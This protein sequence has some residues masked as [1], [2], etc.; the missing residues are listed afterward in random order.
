MDKT[1]VS[2]R[3]YGYLGLLPFLLLSSFTFVDVNHAT[4]WRDAYISYSAVILAFMAGVYWPLGLRHD[5]P[6][7]GHRLMAIAI[8]GALVAWIAVVLPPLLSALSFSSAFLLMFMIDRFVLA[9]YWPSAYLQMRAHLTGV[10]V[11]TQVATL[12]AVH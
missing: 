3:W 10:V 6:A 11:L 4:L 7:H 9:D 8:A 2:M 1:W 5:A 12:I